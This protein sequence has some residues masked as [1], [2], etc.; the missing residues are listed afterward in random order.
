M[1]NEI[2]KEK[3]RELIGDWRVKMMKWDYQINHLMNIVGLVPEGGLLNQLHEMQQAYTDAIA[4]SVGD[5][6]KWL[7][8]FAWENDYGARGFEAKADKSDKMRKIRTVN[9]LARLIERSL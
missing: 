8:W 6:D 2:S 4:F 1:N 9:Q 5:N 3:R 7:E